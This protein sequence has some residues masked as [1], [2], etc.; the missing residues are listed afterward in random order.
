MEAKKI[1]PKNLKSNAREIVR[2][3]MANRGY[4]QTELA[5]KAGLQGQTNVTGMLN[6]GKSISVEHLVL[7]LNTMGMELV[8][9]DANN[10]KGQEWIIENEMLEGSEEG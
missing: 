9:R 5:K 7:L 8:I 10:K 3:V 2:E 6:R 1:N 4:T